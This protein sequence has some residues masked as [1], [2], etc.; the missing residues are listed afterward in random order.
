M[1]SRDDEWKRLYEDLRKSF[2]T[3]GIEDPYGEGD[4]WLV[5]DDYG[6]TTHKLCVHSK[7]FLTL[8]LIRSIQQALAAFPHW[9]VMLQIEF[10][11]TGVAHAS[12]GLIIYHHTIEEHWDRKLVA[13]LVTRLA[14]RPL[15]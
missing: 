5:D 13:D 8:A 10:P 12:S 6:D 15:P 7:T 4:Y 1:T 11:I 14:L 9:R 2:N 3:L